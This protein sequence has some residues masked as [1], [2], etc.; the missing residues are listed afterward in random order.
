[1]L[2]KTF[3]SSLDCKQIKPINPKGNQPWIFI[4]KTDA[5]VEVLI[6]WPPDEKSQLIREDSDAG[7]D[8]EQGVKWVTE[9]EMAEKHHSLN[10]HEFEQILED[11]EAG[12]H[13][14]WGHKEL[15]INELLNNNKTV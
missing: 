1:M 8:L 11:R 5:K 14:P 15:D 9:D 10:E 6:Y 13:S 4:R 3:E 2:Q 12:A 7:K